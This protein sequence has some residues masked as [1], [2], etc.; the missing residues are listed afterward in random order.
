MAQVQIIAAA[1]FYNPGKGGMFGRE[2]NDKVWG[3][4]KI[5]GT[6]VRFWGRRNGRLKFKTEI[7]GAPIDMLRAKVEKG[8][9]DLG[10]ITTDRLMPSLEQDLVAHYFSDLRR[11]L[12]NTKH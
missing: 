3:I 7:N 9:Q 2:Q 11:G 12:V 6:M 10:P 1:H 4:A 8:Y 5:E